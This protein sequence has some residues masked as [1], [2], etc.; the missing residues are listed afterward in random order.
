MIGLI[1]VWILIPMLVKEAIMIGGGLS[2]YLKHGKAV[3][4]SNK[5]G[6]IATFSLYAAILTIILNFNM[7][8]SI[9]LL[10]I[11]VILNLVAFYNYMRIFKK[12]LNDEK[13]GK[14]F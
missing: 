1:P 3:I 8:L 4:P 5:Y 9:I 7:T 10:S 12:L 11:T 2:L 14:G 13:A 6:K